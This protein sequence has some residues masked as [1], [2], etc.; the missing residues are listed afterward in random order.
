MSEVYCNN[1]SDC[2]F[3]EYLRLS[4]AWAGFPGLQDFEHRD[5]DLLETLRE[6]LLPL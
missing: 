4:F 3:V 2:G 5:E 1:P 6:G